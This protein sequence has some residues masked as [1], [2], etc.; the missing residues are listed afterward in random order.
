MQEEVSDAWGEP[1]GLALEPGT[2][3]AGFTLEERLA[4]GGSGTVYRASRGG[5]RVALKV[6]PKDAW[7]EREVDALRRVRHA[8]VVGLLGYGMW[9]EKK[10]RY[11][12]LTLELIEG[13]ALD[14]WAREHNPSARQ[15]VRQVLLPLTRALGQVHAV[16]VVHRDVKESNIVMRKTSGLPVLVDFGAARYTGAPRLTE[17]LPPGTQEYR[18]PEVLRF[19]LEWDGSHYPAGPADDLWA[20]GVTT[21]WLLTRELPFGDR[22]GPLVKTILGQA[23]RPVQEHNPRAPQALGEV[24]LRMLEKELPARYA[25]AEALARALEEVLARADATWDMPLF[26][27]EPGKPGPLVPSL[28]A[29]PALFQAEGGP[30]P[31][32]ARTPLASPG[33]WLTLLTGMLLALSLWALTRRAALSDEAPE[34][35]RAESPLRVPSRQAGIRQEVALAEPTGE[36]GSNAGPP[37]SSSPAPV[38]HATHR[39]DAPMNSSHKPRSTLAALTLGI[40]TCMAPGCVSAPQPVVDPP[41]PPIPCPPG[42]ARTYRQHLPA[43]DWDHGVTIPS[44]KPDRIPRVR[45]GEPV[46]TRLAGHWGDIPDNTPVM[47]VT[48]FGK[49]RVYGRLTEILLPTGERLPVCLDLEFNGPGIP[50]RP[51]STRTEALTVFSVIAVIAPESRQ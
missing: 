39:Q 5:Q 44:T 51:G 20:L 6:V 35:S 4:V 50:M 8:Q 34:A 36:V 25:D 12:V 30:R 21:Y 40:T 38:A 31:E 41:P 15:L 3:V 45:N 22:S 24:C 19:A 13:L 10:P 26:P 49:D 2:Q 11:L 18:S 47:G 7:G 28:E 9:P 46:R 23:P 14:A 43:D 16:G 27:P 32:E 42:A 29:P 17:R 33:A 1:L 48:W 37:K